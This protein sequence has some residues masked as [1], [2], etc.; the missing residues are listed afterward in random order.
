MIDKIKAEIERLQTLT[1]DDNKNFPNSYNEG[2][3]DALT[4]IDNFIDSLLEN[5]KLHNSF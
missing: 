3:F 4:R 5:E 2:M 1:M